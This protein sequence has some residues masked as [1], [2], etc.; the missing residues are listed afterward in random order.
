MPRSKS[1]DEANRNPLPRKAK[2]RKQDEPDVLFAGWANFNF[3]SDQKAEY[4]EWESTGAWADLL[5]ASQI[6][7]LKI[8]LSHNA[9]QDA[10]LATAFVRDPDSVNAGLMTSQRS[11]TSTRALFKLLWAV[12]YGMGEDWAALM[13]AGSHDW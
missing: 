8:T 3:S 10:F 6:G 5:D 4:E 11:G 9:E 1:A 2:Q 12:Y 7:R 13:Q